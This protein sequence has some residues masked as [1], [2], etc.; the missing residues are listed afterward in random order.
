[1]RPHAKDVRLGRVIEVA[2]CAPTLGIGNQTNRLSRTSLCEI[3]TVPGGRRNKTGVT[4]AR[5]SADDQ[6]IVP[7]LGYCC[8]S[9]GPR[10]AAPIEDEDH[11]RVERIRPG[12]RAVQGDG[13]ARAPHAEQQREEAG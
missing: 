2:Q 3:Q 11:L 1:M 12:L 10:V 13:D 8:N 5:S 9:L 7:G 4:R 6:V